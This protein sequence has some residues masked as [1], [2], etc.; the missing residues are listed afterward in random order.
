LP[1]QQMDMVEVT[2]DKV[3]HVFHHLVESRVVATLR[4]PQFCGLL[5]CTLRIG[6]CTKGY[7]TDV[8]F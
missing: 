6:H 3:L 2:I 8:P 4:A 5:N 7:L 1:D